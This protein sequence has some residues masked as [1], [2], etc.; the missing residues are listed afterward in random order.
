VV[1]CLEQGADCLHMVQLTHGVVCLLYLCA[2]DL[3]DKVRNKEL[4]LNGEFLVCCSILF[5]C[6]CSVLTTQS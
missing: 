1:I 5:I 4:S 2:A 3:L 6:Q